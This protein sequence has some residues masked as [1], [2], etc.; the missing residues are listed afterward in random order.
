MK[1][2]AC[3][4]PTHT[5]AQSG[6][7]MCSPLHTPAVSL[8]HTTAPS[9]SCC[10][11]ISLLPLAELVLGL[12]GVSWS[13]GIEPVL[14][15]GLSLKLEGVHRR[16]DTGT[17]TEGAKAPLNE[18]GDPRASCSHAGSCGGAQPNSALCLRV[19]QLSVYKFLNWNSSL[20][21]SWA[22]FSILQLYPLCSG[23]RLEQSWGGKSF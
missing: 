22:S 9:S 20:Y 1:A 16:T 12:A 15:W 23:Y 6:Q 2:E 7:H 13:S 11:V 10:L 18:S 5:S 19:S 17:N 21:L 4:M 3:L 8:W 14:A